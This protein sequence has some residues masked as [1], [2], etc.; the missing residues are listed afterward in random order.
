MERCLF[1]VFNEGITVK[2]FEL[3][4]ITS[5]CLFFPSRYGIVAQGAQIRFS[6]GPNKVFLITLSWANLVAFSQ[7]IIIISFS[8]LPVT[9]YSMLFVDATFF[10]D[11][12]ADYIS[13]VLAHGLWVPFLAHH[14]AISTFFSLLKEVAH[15]YNES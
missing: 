5:F 8:S 7:Q 13:G 11:P 15:S 12:L 2:I 6:R 9:F 1:N 4:T 3:S 10:F 14:S